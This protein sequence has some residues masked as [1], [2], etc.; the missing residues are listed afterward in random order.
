M[1]SVKLL[2]V[3]WILEVLRAVS[4]KFLNIK[5]RIEVD[6]YAETN[7]E[8]DLRVAPKIVRQ[9]II[10]DQEV[11]D[12]RWDLCQGCE[13]LTEANRCTKCGC[14]MKVKHKLSMAKCPI[15]KWGKYKGEVS[16]TTVTI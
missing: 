3:E 13:F 4:I 2:V 1:E 14:F 7:E 8:I 16:G 11:L 15:G 12:M 9:A 10:H 6:K 5:A